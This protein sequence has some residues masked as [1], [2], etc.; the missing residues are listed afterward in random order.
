MKQ[1]IYDDPDYTVLRFTAGQ[2]NYY[3]ELQNVTFEV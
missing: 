3:H 2:A 1:N